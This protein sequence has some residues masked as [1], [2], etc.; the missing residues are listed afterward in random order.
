MQRFALLLVY[1]VSSV[2]AAGRKDC[3]CCL[4]TNRR[5]WLLLTDC[6]CSFVNWCVTA[7]WQTYSVLWRTTK[8]IDIAASLA[9][10]VTLTNK[11]NKFSALFHATNSATPSD[12]KRYD[13][14]VQFLLE[15]KAD[16]KQ[17]CDCDELYSDS[18]AL[19][20]A[21]FKG[22]SNLSETLLRFGADPNATAAGSITPSMC[23]FLPFTRKALA[24]ASGDAKVTL[25]SSTALSETLFVLLKHKADIKAP[26]DSSQIS[27][28]FALQ[29][30]HMLTNSVSTVARRFFASACLQGSMCPSMM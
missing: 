22:L 28:S 19:H 2:A 16:V 18:T 12:E 6:V 23:L 30:S 29:V 1:V 10:P 26:E 11:K 3:R 14:V 20:L 17:Q 15:Q 13:Q 24:S 8:D 27:V 5:L 7:T 4:G 25:Q 21:V 9:S